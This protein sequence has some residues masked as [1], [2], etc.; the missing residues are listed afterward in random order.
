MN[1]CR[2]SSLILGVSYFL[3]GFAHAQS[4]AQVN[5]Q[6][7]QPGAV[8]SSN[9]FG[10]FFE[11]INYGGEGGLYAEMVRNRAFYNPTNA[12]FWTL[13]TQGSAAGQMSVDP[14]QPL[15]PS[16]PNSLKLAMFSG[17]GSV[18][19][20]NS[21][22]WGM[23][24]QA[25]ATYDLNFYACATN[26]FAGPLAARLESAAGSILYAQTS[27][28]GLT[29]NWQHFSSALVAGGS[30]TNARIVLSISQPG[31]I[32]LDVVSLFP[33]ATFHNRTNGL[34]A[35][36]GNMLAALQ[37]AFLRF[38]GGNY[39][40]SNTATNAV[41]WKKSIG[42]IAQRPGHLNDS[43]GYW[44]TDGFGAQE[45]FQFCEDLGMQPL[46]GINAGL[47]L[48]YNGATNNT[49][50][51]DQMGPWVQDAVDLIQY[52]TGDSNTV[53]GAQRAAN[54]HPAPFNFNLL[55][56]GNENGGAY[57]DARYSLF[58]DAIK[59]N[60][61][62]VKLIS[63]GNWSGGPPTSRPRE[64][65]DEHYYSSPATFLSY[66]AKYDNY[67]RSGPKVFVGEYAVT[68]GFGTYGNL[69][70]ALGEAAFMT[71]MERNSDVVQ[72][73]SYAP[74][75]ANVNGIQWHP[76]LIYY[77]NSQA[78]GTPSYYVQQMFSVNRG[79]VILPATVAWMT[80]A[81]ATA[82]HGAIGVGSWNTAVQYTN[83][84]VTS[85]GVTLYQSDFNANGANGWS[86]HNGSWN[87][88]AGLYQQTSA[89]TT[90]CRSTTGSTNWANYTL[91]L[92]ARKLSGS[93]GFLV[94]FNWTDDNDWTWWN[95]GGWGN[96][97]DGVEQMMGGTK[98]TLASVSQA[99][100]ATNTWYDLR[101]V[102]T[103]GTVQCYLNN[104]LVQT[105]VYPSGIYAS[106]TYSRAS[107]QVIVK[108]VNPY[109]SPLATTFNL[110][111]VSGIASNA[112][113]IQLTSPS[114]SDENSFAAPTY[115]GPLTNYLSN[116][117]TNFALTLP[118]NSFSVLKLTAN[119]I[120][121][122]SNL[123]LQVPSSL[124]SGV[125]VATVV[126]GQ[127]SGNW[128]N[129]TSNSNHALTWSTANTNVAVVDI[130]GT[131]TGLSSGTTSIIARYPALNLSAT[132]SVQVITS[133]TILVHRY[134]FSETSGS[135][136]ADSV[137]G[138]A[139]NGFLPRGG[140]LGGGQL[141]LASNLQQYLQLPAGILSNYT[142][143]TVEA[144][145]TFPD[146]LPVNCFF[147]GFGNSI[148]AAGTNYIFCAPRAG[149][150][151]IAGGTYSSE[152]NAY[153]NFDFSFHTNFH[154]TAVFNPPAGNVALYTN[155][156]LAAINSAVTTPLSAVN[157]VYSF[158]ARSLYSGDPYLDCTLDEF[159]IYRGAL[160]TS[161]IAATQVLGPDQLL[162]PGNPVMGVSAS[163][164]VL[165]LAW[166]VGS[167]GFTLL[168]ATN[169]AAGAWSPVSGS[170]QIINNQWQV[171]LPVAAGT[172]FFRL[173]K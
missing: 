169:L 75:F 3:A 5:I 158:I 92:R 111:G 34:R 51:L 93:E 42:N 95:V 71:G 26:G 118:A 7:N 171:I 165:T 80:N 39:I 52:A 87:A 130:N 102:L 147:F 62:D 32:W 135:S 90:D 166:P 88:V 40:E 115:I 21:G 145:V 104:A 94:L 170:P 14:A 126:W 53:W 23:A 105:V 58:Y 124:T 89:S 151:A 19:A 41:R 49:V 144:W 60:Y 50:P 121:N 17:N 137:G 70:A 47:M 153:G 9:L 78:F 161:E 154:L 55:E 157:D 57:Y 123:L 11:E 133:P 61:P 65:S 162:N 66:A 83:L 1:F 25:G 146:Q 138:Q 129:L 131:V 167:A 164:G 113:L 122:Y 77:N 152:Q 172:Q 8:A 15:N 35:D 48:G 22:F 64:I 163:G 6:V 27:Y 82:L 116:A 74:L 142:Q 56:I 139:W 96:T 67:S 76:D 24:L 20:A 43:W 127:Q 73:A 132:Q 106:T 86:V 84:V 30:D 100:I 101:I 156:I 91:S 12:L 68:S 125:P 109:N 120:N 18:G 54:G 110:S 140:Q 148:G 160:S 45:F 136:I 33:R 72:L 134:R 31:T 159:R 4:A 79:D 29:T 44:S 173:Q 114:P 46:Y 59:T 150:I 108:A 98:T 36:L 143:V 117:G 38:P 85:N 103:N 149:R 128:I 107:R 141:T 13:I 97:L 168:A 2:I 28:G 81:S 119:G 10:I 16:L 155:G 69:A 112:T 63:P 37:P 99:A